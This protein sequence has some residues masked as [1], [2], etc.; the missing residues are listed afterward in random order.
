MRQVDLCLVLH[1]HLP[2]VRHPEVEEHGFEWW[3]Y[4]A[5]WEV[6]A[7]LLAAFERL[8]QDGVPFRMTVSIS[9]PLLGMFCDR[10]L[11]ERLER[12]LKRLAVLTDRERER[13]EGGPFQAAATHF[14]YHVRQALDVY[15]RFD[16]N[17]ARGFR[18]WQD[19]GRIEVITT[20]AT[21]GFL[22][23]LQDL[24]ACAGAQVRVGAES[25][26]KFFGRLP[27][28]MWLAECAYMPAHDGLPGVDEWLAD[29]G[30][31]YFFL[32]TH[33][34][35]GA[36]PRPPH[37]VHAPIRTP[38]GVA[39]FGRDPETSKQVWSATEGYP[40]DAW[41][42]EHHKDAGH[43]LDAEQI[44]P[45]RPDRTGRIPIGLK[46]F[47]VTSKSSARKS[48]YAPWMAL[49]RS[50]YH[51]T[52]FLRKRT[53]QSYGLL[54]AIRGETPVIV[55]PYDAELFGHWWH[56]G[57][58][59]IEYIFRKAHEMRL[60]FRFSTPS[61]R[62]RREPVR[63]VATPAA[64]S[65]GDGGYYRVWLNGT[66]DQMV[67]K[68][69]K[70]GAA[71]LRAVREFGRSDLERRALAQMGR[72]LLLAQSSDW[73]FIATTSQGIRPYAHEKV[74]KFLTRFWGILR[75]LRHGGVSAAML[76]SLE[77]DDNL[78]P[79]LTAKPWLAARRAPLVR[80]RKRIVPETPALGAAERLIRRETA[81]ELGVKPISP[82]LAFVWWDFK[83]LKGRVTDLRVRCL[84]PPVFERQVPC[85]A[86]SG[87]WYIHKL[88]PGCHYQLLAFG[89]G[90]LQAYSVPALLPGKPRT[91]AARWRRFR[92]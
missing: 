29:S 13:T 81:E 14:Y 24:P 21:H 89:D 25:H 23:H 6:Y 19:A 39:V 28:G 83:T 41:Y 30:V 76:E 34:I 91:H 85:A 55:A 7:P 22:P 54:S 84:T 2:Y 20:P 68:L 49:R 35:T 9:A 69:T 48:P 57:P 26:R 79:W 53:A 62:L 90:V 92:D 74:D 46:Y 71:H 27:A 47:R 78:F 86:S 65:W 38:A 73:P 44:R 37:G 16:S 5:C 50:A 64:S 32:D 66:N 51:A 11:N 43:F 52:H 33:G 1:A 77:A 88:R 40:G 60:P 18:H 15:R 12:H 61:D 58:K 31:R 8:E 80:P 42:A 3:F 10:L 59:F 56:E 82:F 72:E 4:E 45:F 17:L 70:A 75:A 36:G 67:S 63:H 87:N